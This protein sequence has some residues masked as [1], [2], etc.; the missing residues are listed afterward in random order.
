MILV[1]GHLRIAAEKMDEARPHMRAVLEATRKEAGCILYAF[2]EDVLD[3][4]LIRI[5]EEWESSDALKAHGGAPHLGAWRQA[6]KTIG[7]LDR[8]VTA[9]VAGE[10]RAL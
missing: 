3:R 4:G 7:V 6:L 10:S 2:A 9:Y 5:L 8:E 1:M